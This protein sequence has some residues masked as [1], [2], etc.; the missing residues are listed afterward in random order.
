LKKFQKILETSRILFYLKG[1]CIFGLDPIYNGS[2]EFLRH[3]TRCV[4]PSPLSI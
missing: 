2:K 3:L 1:R 4:D